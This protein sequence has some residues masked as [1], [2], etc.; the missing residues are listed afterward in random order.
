MAGAFF[1]VPLAALALIIAAIPVIRLVHL[2]ID[3]QLDVGLVIAGGFLYIA[4]VVSV[5]AGP[6]AVKVGA[7]VLILVSAVLFPFFSGVSADVENKRMDDARMQAYAAALERNPADPVARI[8]L[9]EELEKRGDVDQA[10]EHLGWTLREFPKLSIQH[11][12]TLEAWK[13][14]VARRGVPQTFFCHMC[15]AEQL[16]GATMC[17]ECGAMFGTMDGV[18]QRVI[19]EGG[20][21]VILRAWIIGVPVI[22][23]ALF[24]LLELPS[25]IAGPIILASVCVGAWLFLRWVGGDIG[26]P[27]D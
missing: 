1:G 16:P 26:R 3:G 25:I 6:S 9:A 15:H 17:S 7:L 23:L 13:R 19:R 8:A 12:A 2:A 27:M 11:Q 24:L 18:R 14:E 4:L 22:M 5:A 10:I 20:P 21:R